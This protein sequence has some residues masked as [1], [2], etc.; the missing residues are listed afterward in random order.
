M[1]FSTRELVSLHAVH[2]FAWLALRLL[3]PLRAQSAVQRVAGLAGP[4]SSVGDARAG[5]RALGSLGSCLSRSIAVSALLPGSQVVIGVA[6]HAPDGEPVL[7]AHAWVELGNT[8]LDAPPRPGD[9]G[10]DHRPLARLPGRAR[11]R[12]LCDI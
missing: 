3:P 1:A 7:R 6:A 8:G 11:Q 4:F 10:E 12:S 9:G 2:G 5:I